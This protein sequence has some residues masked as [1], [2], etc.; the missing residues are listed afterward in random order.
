[1]PPAL[2]EKEASKFKIKISLPKLRPACSSAC[3]CERGPAAP[4]WPAKQ[5]ATEAAESVVAR[6]SD[7][8]SALRNQPRSSRA[9]EGR[10]PGERR[11]AGGGGK[12]TAG[13]QAESNVFSRHKL[14]DRLRRPRRPRRP[15]DGRELGPRGPSTGGQVASAPS[16]F[17]L[18]RAAGTIARS[19]G[20]GAGRCC[21]WCRRRLRRASKR[22]SPGRQRVPGTNLLVTRASRAGRRARQLRGSC[23]M[24]KV[25]AGSG[26]RWDGRPSGRGEPS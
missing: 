24:K 8:A 23:I 7:E 12:V 21:G 10:A 9:L 11:G 18:P 6:R 15:A 25:C 3:A 1:M 2:E 4:P 17:N 13:R 22:A 16:I 20:A 26:K 5:L 14:I 19:P